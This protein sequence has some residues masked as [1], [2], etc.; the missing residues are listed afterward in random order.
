MKLKCIKLVS[1]LEEDYPL[2]TSVFVTG[3]VS[4]FLVINALDLC[5]V[6]NFNATKRMLGPFDT[7][8]YALYANDHFCTSNQFQWIV[9]HRFWKPKKEEEEAEKNSKLAAAECTQNPRWNSIVFQFFSSLPPFSS[10]SSQT[11]WCLIRHLVTLVANL[12]LL[13]I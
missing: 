3:Y 2:S 11:H 4:F 8:E 12:M 6:V 5:W 10:H 9:S 13:H 7:G 1:M